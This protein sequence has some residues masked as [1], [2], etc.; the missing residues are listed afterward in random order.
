MQHGPFPP[1]KQSALQEHRAQQHFPYLGRDTLDRQ[2]AIFTITDTLNQLGQASRTSTLLRWLGR[3]DGME[4]HL[5]EDQDPL[6]CVRALLMAAVAARVSRSTAN[7]SPDDAGTVLPLNRNG[8]AGWVFEGSV[9]FVAKRLADS[10][11]EWVKTHE[12]E[13]AIP[14][15]AKND[16]LFDTWQEYGVIDL[17]PATGQAIWYVEV[18][19]NEAEQGGYTHEFAMLRF[20]LSK[21]YAQ[22]G[23]YPAPMRGHLV[24]KDKRKA[25]AED[26][27]DLAPA[28][29]V[30]DEHQTAAAEG[31]SHQDAATQSNLH[32][33]APDSTNPPETA[34]VKQA[35]RQEA[36]TAQDRKLALVMREPAFSKPPQAAAAAKSNGKSPEPKPEAK[37]EPRPEAKQRPA[38]V[39]WLN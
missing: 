9:W 32:E 7:E 12:P 11:R 14:G 4:A 39:G 20:P 15:Q 22:E 24:I 1:I 17:N 21:L 36:A 29:T 8:A 28:L 23:M 37:L 25:G 6:L 27:Q 16:R 31:N 35:K 38:H 5:E 13:E 19:G 33:V 34:P 30:P 10:V 18:H 2:R 26:Q 3:F